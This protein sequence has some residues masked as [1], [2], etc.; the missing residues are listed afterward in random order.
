MAEVTTPTR[1]RSTLD[2]V[3]QRAI[4]DAERIRQNAGI[5]L[6]NERGDP[7]ELGIPANVTPGVDPNLTLTDRTSISIT[8]EADV[9]PAGTSG[10]KADSG[11]GTAADPYVYSGYRF[12]N[13][14]GQ[15][16]AVSWTDTTPTYYVK[17][18]NCEFSGYSSSV[19][20]GW[21]ILLL[22]LGGTESD[23]GIEF[24]ECDFWD[25]TTAADPI[26]RV[27][28]GHTT[29]TNCRI[30]GGF[31]TGVRCLDNYGAIRE[32][33]I[34]FNGCLVDEFKAA[35]ATGSALIANEKRHPWTVTAKNCEIKAPSLYMGFPVNNM[36]ASGFSVLSCIFDG[37]V[38][39]VN[40]SGASG[41]YIPE[42]LPNVTGHYAILESTTKNWEVKY[43]KFMGA[44]AKNYIGLK[45]C[46]DGDVAYNEFYS[47]AADLRQEVY[48]PNKGGDYEHACRNIESHH[49]YYERTSGTRIAGN[50]IW[51]A[52][53]S[54]NVNAHDSWVGT[55][56]EDA[57]E[58]V[59]CFDCNMYNLVAD[60]C[61]G[62]VANP[63]RS[64]ASVVTSGKVHHIYGD[65]DELSVQAANITVHDIYCYFRARGVFVRTLAA[66][67]RVFG[68]LPM[69]NPITFEDPTITTQVA[70]YEHNN[71]LVVHDPGGLISDT[72][73]LALR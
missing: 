51:E 69:V 11:T 52:F 10:S 30:R 40:S 27:T 4:F 9:D 67:C 29:F 37:V 15:P 32:R 16:H 44:N 6:T 34:T 56:T 47:N 31:V 72:T 73:R 48:A 24:E 13:S 17:F 2:T 7:I 49:N 59:D 63:Y 18:V 61:V 62:D 1:W 36:G 23:Y 45:R 55:C 41:Q 71:K 60:N 39:P 66:N 54:Y 28:N 14:E 38:F 35:W 50:E 25:T 70:V 65:A 58:T 57:W 68:P 46:A 43:S 12:N 8:T 19:N 20:T 26:A 3:R 33:R 22:N 21:A 53:E 64:T 5:P 42:P